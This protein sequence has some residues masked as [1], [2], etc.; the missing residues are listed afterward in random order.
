MLKLQ[1]RKHAYCLT[2]LSITL[3]VIIFWLFKFNLGKVKHP[4]LRRFFEAFRDGFAV[5][6]RLSSPGLESVAG[7]Q[8]PSTFDES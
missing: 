6:I 3:L 1:Y 8:N 5:P 7:Q 4:F 2:K